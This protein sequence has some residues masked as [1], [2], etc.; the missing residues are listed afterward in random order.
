M[1]E[2]L[3]KISNNGETNISVSGVSGAS[4]QSYTKDLEEALG[5]VISGQKKPEFYYEENQVC[6]NKV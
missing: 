4:C 3:I 1:A 5:T 6:L 2:L